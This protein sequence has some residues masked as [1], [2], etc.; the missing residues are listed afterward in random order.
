[1]ETVK[2][3]AFED[4]AKIAPY[5]NNPDFGYIKLASEQVV[6][7]GVWT[8]LKKRT[9]LLRGSVD[10]LEMAYG[11]KDSLPGKIRVV[12]CLE[13]DIP[14][15]CLAT[16]NKKEDFE[17]QISSYIKT[18]GE[19]G[20]ALKV[21]DLRILHFYFYDDSGSIADIRIQHDPIA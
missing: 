12:E 21:G 6:I 2:I 14:A 11:S 8:R 4:G 15:E 7:N 16:L 1:M 19:D 9:A 18:A 13:N 5:K 20:N 10:V 17:T 3:I